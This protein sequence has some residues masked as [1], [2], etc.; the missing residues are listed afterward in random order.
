LS[1][2]GDPTVVNRRYRSAY[3]WGFQSPAIFGNLWQFWQSYPPPAP[4]RLPPNF[5]QGHPIHPRI[6]RGS[7]SAVSSKP[8][9][10]GPRRAR[11]WRAGVEGHPIP[12]PPTRAVFRVVGWNTPKDRQRV[13]TLKCQNPA[14]QPGFSSFD[15]RV[16][17]P[18][19]AVLYLRGNRH[20]L[21]PVQLSLC[22]HSA[23]NKIRNYISTILPSRNK[24]ICDPLPDKDRNCVFDTVRQIWISSPGE[25]I[26]R[27][28][29][30]RGTHPIP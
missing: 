18:P 16:A 4:P 26:S 3:C 15:S 30:S 13:T 24:K 1:I 22:C 11:F 5:T 2:S 17:Q 28:D 23:T 29:V 27:V 25:C 20:S 6:S 21:L 7:H 8:S 9:I 12:G 14:S 19:S 10:R